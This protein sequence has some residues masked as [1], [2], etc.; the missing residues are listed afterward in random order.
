MPLASG[1]V[2]QEALD[3]LQFCAIVENGANPPIPPQPP[4]N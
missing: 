4:A 1:F 3:L 2:L